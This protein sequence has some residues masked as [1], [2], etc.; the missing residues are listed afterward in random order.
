MPITK[1]N[2]LIRPSDITGRFAY[3]HHGIGMVIFGVFT[4]YA[5]LIYST[6]YL[7]EMYGMSLVAAS[8][9]GIESTK[10][11]ARCAAHLAA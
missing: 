8:Y 6:S 1:K 10:Y 3:Q 11:S 2:S 9:M 7:T 4:I 5:I